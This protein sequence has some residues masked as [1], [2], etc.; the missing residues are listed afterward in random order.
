MSKLF[1][2]MDRWPATD[3]WLIVAFLV[4][5]VVVAVLR[6]SAR[7]SPPRSRASGSR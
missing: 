1:E 4:I 7:P 6:R 3:V 2:A 5:T